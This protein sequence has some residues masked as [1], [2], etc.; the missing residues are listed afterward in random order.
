MRLATLLFVLVLATACSS[1]ATEDP[2]A[3][4]STAQAQRDISSVSASP[5]DE[6]QPEPAADDKVCA[7]LESDE[8]AAVLPDAAAEPAPALTGGILSCQWPSEAGTYVQ[9][10]STRASEW[11]RALPGL[12]AQLEA[13]GVITSQKA[14]SKLRAGARLI[15]RDGAVDDQMACDLFSRLL[16]LQGQRPGTHHIA[17]IVPTRD[18]PQGVTAQIC[19]GGQ[20]TS[21]MVAD[22][23]GL[24]APLPVEQVVRAAQLAHRRALGDG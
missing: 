19:T 9:L 1:G 23:A 4:G 10:M 7:L 21:V 2:N 15:E 22:P 13:G 18:D 3:T 17:T 24:A 8:V 12:V 14:L 16:E 20:F 11:S 5:S 6:V